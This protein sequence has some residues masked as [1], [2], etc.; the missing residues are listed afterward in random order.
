M[1]GKLYIV[2]TRGYY[3]ELTSLIGKSSRG[4]SLGRLIFVDLGS[5]DTVTDAGLLAHELLH[6]KVG[7]WNTL[8]MSPALAE[9][10]HNAIAIFQDQIE[11]GQYFSPIP[12]PSKR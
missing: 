7:F 3:N 6:T 8:R 4:L 10:Y 9:K 5:G 2:N 12:V 1:S 11:K